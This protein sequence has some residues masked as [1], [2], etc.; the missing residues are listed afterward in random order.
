MATKEEM[1]TN[2]ES[3]I[4]AKMKG[5]AVESYSINGRNIKY[6][7]LSELIKWRNQLK[8]EI[9]SENGSRNYGGFSNPS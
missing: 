7:N 4:D 6:M 3:A 2:V 1:L 5:G 8:A 9:S